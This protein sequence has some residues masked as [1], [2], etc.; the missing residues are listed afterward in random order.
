M[1]SIEDRIVAMK[2]D[3]ATFE[4]GVGTT[5]NS[6][7]KLKTSLEFKNAGKGLDDLATSQSRFNMNGVSGAV[8]GVSNKFLALST[9]ALTVLS[10][11]TS[12]AFDSGLSIAKSLTIDPIKS[13]LSEYETNLN[14]IQT[15]LANTQSKG[16][17]L[18][19]VNAALQQLN[20]YS[21]KTIY[22]FSEMAKNVGTFTSA[23]VGLDKSVQSIKGIANLA[24]LSGSNSE[25]ASTAMYQLSQ[26]I[27][28]GS[29]KLMDWNSVVNAGMGGEVFQKALFNNAKAMKTLTGVPVGQTFEEWTKKG[30]SFRTQ[31]ESGFVTAD[32]LTQTL[33]QFT[34][35]LTDAQLKSQGFTADQIKQIQT[36]A[37]TASDAATK[38]K[39]L[40]QLLGTLKEANG[41]GWTQ[42]WQYIFGDFGEAKDAFTSASNTLGGFISAN[43]DARNKILKDWHDLG[44]RA[45][46]IQSIKNVFQALMDILVPVRDAFHEFFP[47]K[48]GQDLYNFSLAIQTLTERLKPSEQTIDRFAR[49]ASGFFAV[50]DI[51]KFLLQEVIRLFRR[52]FSSSGAGDGTG[53]L[54]LTAGLGDV[55]VD[56]RNLVVSGGGVEKFFDKLGDILV[57]PIKL[58]GKLRD[59][60]GALFENFDGKTADA[61]AS[62]LDGVGKALSPMSRIGQRLNSVW[63]HLV[64]L[65]EKIRDIAAPIIAELTDQLK[66]LGQAIADG[67]GSG[68]FDKALDIINTGLLGG[69]AALIYKFFKSGVNIDLGGGLLGQVRNSLEMLTGTA[70]A[71]QTQIKAKALLLIAGAIALLT[72]SV[73][74]LSLIDSAALTRALTAMAVGFGQLL[75]G[76]A[77]LTK[78]AGAK[79][80]IK[81]PAIAAALVLLGAAILVMSVALKLLSTLSWEEI[82]KGLTGIAGILAALSIAVIPLSANSSGMIRA[83]V[84]MIAIGVALNILY[85][86][87]K[88]FGSLDWETL[89]KG[90]AGV[91]L[92]LGAIGLAMQVFPPNVL[93]NAVALGFIATALLILAKSVEQFADFK[94]EEMGKGLAGIGLTIGVIGVA[95]NVFPPNTVASAIA[96]TIVAG[97]LLILQ[98]ALS[99]F[100]GMSWSDIGKGL[101][102]VAAT[103][104]ILVAAMTVATGALPGAAA[105]L[106][107]AGALA[108]LV[109]VLKILGGMSW[110]SIAK[111]LVTLAGVFVILGIAGL[112]LTPLAPVLIVL[113]AAILALGAG[114]ALLGAG[115]LAFAAAFAIF[116]AVG[117]AGAAVITAVL[118]AIIALIPVALTSLAVGLIA[119]A[120]AIAKGLPAFVAAFTTLIVALL[121]A[122][123]DATPKIEETML[124]LIDALLNVIVTAEPKIVNAALVLVT[125]L[126]QTFANNLP[127]II[128]AAANV[129]IAFITGLANNSGRIIQAAFDALITFIN[130]LTQAINQNSDRLFDAGYDL[131]GAIIEGLVKGLLNGVGRVAGAAADVAKGAAGKIGGF[132][133]IHSPSRLMKEYGQFIDEGL[134]LGL[135]DKGFATAAAGELAGGALNAIKETMSHISDLVTNEVD[136]TPVIA[137]VLDLSQVQKDAASLPGL[138]NVTPIT[139]AAS[140]QAASSI[141]ASQQ[142]AQDAADALATPVEPVVLKFEQ[143]NTSPEAISTIDVYRN[144]KN[145]L[146]M[147]KE[148]LAI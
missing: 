128:A 17:T 6:L 39:T 76:M 43:A 28:S 121:Q 67:L 99:D 135:T 131:A 102:T 22:N 44:G 31:L 85:F 122:I 64:F 13:G 118:G 33:A 108:V 48:T 49:T 24:A 45:V 113:A 47:K 93:A 50:L 89:G 86:A 126:L 7:D 18:D 114:I 29:V 1:S 9:I 125:A 120:T 4:K 138:F 137:P 72:A 51:G 84:A 82:G 101:V 136:M 140:Y 78:V 66:N 40:T 55:L 96:L 54:G 63:D 20:E 94:W 46:I 42:T 141:S 36:Q 91:G 69:I 60:I 111:G 88:N 146:S 56:L 92:T 105:V 87:V 98:K 77:I 15:T 103:L 26:A 142:Q 133:G 147:A 3:N 61:V 11:I 144:T 68:N 21:D 148:A 124:T 139:A 132:F 129:I 34:G 134:A 23:G 58:L 16:T 12:K 38:V 25:Q 123:I 30:G 75:A 130:G 116:T 19:Q 107:M 2:F 104:L 106:I 57:V 109:P 83:S 112:V 37:K 115:A 65:F 32:V 62:G 127:K 80:F 71:M 81:I 35:D 95:L 73:V 143:N 74:V 97:A 14:A 79:G 117:T 41:S 53:F 8:D 100:A 119:F 145:L 59:V 70:K 27:A 10:R 5:I 90:L 110:E 52:L